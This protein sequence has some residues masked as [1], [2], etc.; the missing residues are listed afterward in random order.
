MTIARPLVGLVVKF[1][2]TPALPLPEDVP[3]LP[4]FSGRRVAEE[5]DQQLRRQG[6]LASRHSAVCHEPSQGD[7]SLQELVREPDRGD[8][9]ARKSDDEPFGWKPV[10]QEGR[11][12][13][14]HHLATMLAVAIRPVMPLGVIRGIM[15]RT[16]VTRLLR[17]SLSDADESICDPRGAGGVP[18]GSVEVYVVP[19]DDKHSKASSVFGLAV[20]DPKLRVRVPGCAIEAAPLVQHG[21]VAGRAQGTRQ[22]CALWAKIWTSEPKATEA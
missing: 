3:S 4:I 8:A 2:K 20:S 12:E 18:E 15:R 19:V 13:A 7:T 6:W 1:E 5:R 22:E 9:A 21:P 11:F 14:V 17:V 16:A 10:C